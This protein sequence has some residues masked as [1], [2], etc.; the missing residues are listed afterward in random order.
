MNLRI[1]RVEAIPIC[2]PFRQPF[3]DAHGSK[4]TSEY[5]LVR[6]ETTAGIVGLGEAT[7][8]ATWSG[9]TQVS[10]KYAIE[11]L[12]GP[13]ILAADATDVSR[14]AARMDQV[15]AG[16]P[17]TKAAVEMALWDIAARAANVPLFQLLGGRVRERVHLKMSVPA[18]DPT[19]AASAAEQAAALGMHAVKVKVGTDPDQD[20]ARVKEVRRSVGDS[21]PLGVDANGGWNLAE[22]VATLRTLTSAGLL[23]AEQPVPAGDPLQLA[24]VRRQVGIPIMADETVW[25][26]GDLLAVVRAE[27]ADIVNLYPGKNGGI[28]KCLRLAA[29]AEAARLPCVMGSNL[30][31]GVGSAAMVHLAVA[32][33]ALRP[34]RYPCDII[35]PLYHAGDVVRQPVPIAGGFA[36]PPPGPGLGVDL[37]DEQ[38]A[39]FRAC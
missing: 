19:V 23:F 38:V 4:E 10:A 15:L 25:T 31:L 29:V 26:S 39:R 34:E 35:G 22:A 12:I 7:V 36:A 2:V 17:F 8:S 24:A 32:M 20:V 33:T 14:L 3:R 28:G 37:D 5:I 27:A 13:S 11:H 9:E 21:F 18:A 30:E 6:V 16:N 1:R